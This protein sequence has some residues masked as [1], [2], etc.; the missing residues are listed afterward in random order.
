V[1][2]RKL[3][4][5]SVRLS[6]SSPRGGRSSITRGICGGKE[7]HSVRGFYLKYFGF[8]LSL[9]FDQSA[10]LTHLSVTEN[11]DISKPQQL[12]IISKYKT[13]KLLF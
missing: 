9:S 11:A 12:C 7:K 3:C 8:P 4:R 1:S 10:T 6:L 2:V 13:K 5:G